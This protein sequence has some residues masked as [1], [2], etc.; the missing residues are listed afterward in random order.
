VPPTTTWQ[1]GDLIAERYRVERPLARG[2]MGAVLVVRDERT[3]GQPLALKVI[4]ADV[5]ND[6][7]LQRFHR[8]AALTARMRSLHVIPLRDFGVT[9]QGEPYMV[10]DL[11]QGE[12]LNERL[13]RE[14]PRP[15]DEALRLT[16]EVLAGL[17]D[18]HALGVLHRDVKPAN[19]FLE[20]SESIRDHVRLI[21]LGIAKGLPGAALDVE[22]VTLVASVIGTPTYISPEAVRGERLGPTA[23]LYATALVLLRI[24]GAELPHERTPVGTPD[25]EAPTQAFLHRRATSP[26]EL[27]ALKGVAAMPGELR[28]LLARALSPL[29]DRRP[30]DAFEFR[31]A[32]R[33]AVPGA[34]WSRLPLPRTATT[35]PD[36]T[37]EDAGDSAET[38]IRL[39][40]SSIH[41]ED[42]TA[43]ALP[44]PARSVRGET[45]FRLPLGA[46]RRSLSSSLRV[47][48][49][50]A[51]I[52][53]IAGALAFARM[54][55]N[56]ES[57]QAVT[58]S[59]PSVTDLPTPAGPAK[60]AVVPVD[61][62]NATSSGPPI[63]P[64]TSVASVPTA[65]ASDP[66]TRPAAG[67]APR[68]APAAKATPERGVDCAREM[69]AIAAASS[70]SSLE[71][72]S[73]LCRRV[74]ALRARVEQPPC[75]LDPSARGDLDALATLC[76]G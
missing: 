11:L 63:A 39:S 62:V 45:L 14:G 49:P 2:G 68:S 42:T 30:A 55:S 71:P 61:T 38:V 37:A 64:P 18:L 34:N 29:P 50:L 75:T 1:P 10:M 74:R 5:S 73:P 58:D 6:E 32:L 12:T 40:E 9:E 43:E 7:H 70:S 28:D 21:D 72:G 24:L 76:D 69:K 20:S 51:A 66:P 3:F 16:D 27:D 65:P 23:D 48:A 31:A 53:G 47:A 8:E 33:A 35:P 44:A 26:V 56:V 17:Q 41:L 22:D 25:P 36:S 13:Q 67:T 52:V 4:R 19:I 46:G 59:A 54:H 57:P 60:P 15:L